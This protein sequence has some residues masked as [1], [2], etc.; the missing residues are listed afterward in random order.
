[1]RHCVR[2]D[3]CVSMFLSAEC[4]ATTGVIIH[5]HISFMTASLVCS[6][7]GYNSDNMSDIYYPIK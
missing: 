3:V 5:T 7:S 4:A 6:C 1:M 2:V